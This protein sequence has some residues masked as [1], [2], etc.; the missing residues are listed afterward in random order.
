MNDLPRF[1]VYLRTLREL[2]GLQQEDLAKGLKVSKSLISHF[3]N[4]RRPGPKTVER[5]VKTL[6]LSFKERE[7]LQLIC[8]EEKLGVNL[9]SGRRLLNPVGKEILDQQKF[10]EI[11]VV[12]KRPIELT[13]INERNQFLKAMVKELSGQRSQKYVYFTVR[14]SLTLFGT[15]FH[16]LLEHDVPRKVLRDTFEV[17]LCPSEFCLLSYAIY[18]SSKADSKHD[19]YDR[20]GRILLRDREDLQSFRVAQMGTLEMQQV[21]GFLRDLHDELII[22]PKSRIGFEHHSVD[23]IMA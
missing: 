15:F 23:K 1:G 17:V 11:F 20:V 6:G 5:L 9:D 2:R 7:T 4:N 10:S 16:F 19:E 14:D 22:K 21:Y 12:A 3:E 18:S 8:D 13:E